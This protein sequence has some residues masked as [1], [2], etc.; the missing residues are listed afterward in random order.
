MSLSEPTVQ[1]RRINDIGAIRSWHV[2][3][4]QLHITTN[5][6]AIVIQFYT[7]EIARIHISLHGQVDENPFTVVLQPEQ[8]NTSLDE[9]PDHLIFKSDAL[10]LHIQKVPFRIT[11]F[12]RHGQLLA[13]DD[14][15]LGLAMQG[16]QLTLH[17]KL[18]EGE[19]FIGL[20]EKTGHLDR[21]GAG[22]QNW[23]TDRFAYGSDTDPLYASI[24]FYIGVHSGRV[25]G[26]YLDNSYQT[27]F[28]FGASNNRFSSITSYGGSFDMYFI[29]D[30]TVKDIIGNFTLLTG[31]MPLPPVWSM[32]YQQCRYSYYP[33]NEVLRVAE[34][35]R[36]KRIPADVI[37]L[38]IHYMEQYKI[39]SWDGQRF[40]DPDAMTKKLRSDGF[41]VVVICDPGIKVEK[42][43]E[44][45]ESG[46]KEDIFLKYP[47]GTPYEG[48][49]WPG[50][51]HFPDF[52][53]EEARE[54]WKKN[55]SFYT[56]SGIRG[57]WNDM[58]EIATW[59]NML[60]DNILFDF[61]GDEATT[62]KGR[63]VFGYQMSRA[64]YESAKELLNERPFVLTRSGFAGLQRY[65]AL[66]T[67]DNVSSDESMMVGVRLVNS[68]GLTGVAF[69]GYDVGGFVGNANGHL[70]ARWMQLG[71][72]SPFFRGHT[73]INSNSSEPWSYGEQVEEI[74][75]NFIRLRYK[76]L[77][78]LYSAFR[79]AAL[80]GTPVQRS[81]ALD[82]THD[83]QVYN[84]AFENQYFFGS[85]IL[86]AP[87][88]S[89]KSIQKVYLP[90]GEWF[91]LFSGRR[92]HGNQ[93]LFNECGIERLP[94]YV[95][96]SSVLMLYPEIG[97]N[98]REIGTTLELHLYDGQAETSVTYYED[99]GSSFDFEKGS[100]YARQIHFNAN[101]RKLY[102]SPKEG[103]YSSKIRTI[104]VVMHGFH[105]QS[106]S[107]NG[108]S[109]SP[110]RA[111]YRFIQPISN[112]DPVI[113][114]EDSNLKNENLTTFTIPNEDSDIHIHF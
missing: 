85:S 51:C 18:Q 103:S 76:L 82:Y 4:N 89:Y 60:P 93:E 11:Y 23:N 109:V 6:A 30:E 28:N 10:Q 34:K 44:P 37:V 56:K 87:L 49:V 19:R 41:E 53:K 79:E 21:R 7:Q 1:S 74:T 26:T 112:F 9:H 8:I 31:R 98:T 83:D 113:K 78:H 40:P 29:G 97:N 36:D 105:S 86:V 58:N 63:N 92:T 73:M 107:V 114:M 71:A 111:D 70:F 13:E 64:S 90:E 35:F 15:G 55:L 88:E 100:Y 45:Y 84:H 61:G 50:W 52:T 3:D 99:D 2:A 12:D 54:W 80:N 95:K 57:Y 102:I 14:K 27:N 75:A 32:G 33:Q 62:R 101:E 96:A 91:E 59:G 39:F 24:P 67:G 43:Y 94:V 69:C 65:T 48:A 81:L 77:P 16:E 46:L 108:Q 20:G 68:L 38:D 22:Y 110:Y 104:R 25:Y 47:D 42:G 72:F 66:W 5:A 106:I 17:R